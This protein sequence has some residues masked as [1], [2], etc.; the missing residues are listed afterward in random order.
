M[1]APAALA[2]GAGWI[3]WPKS[4]TLYGLIG[5]LGGVA[6]WL[7]LNRPSHLPGRP[8]A[9]EAPAPP[10]T[11]WGIRDLPAFSLLSMVGFLDTGMRYACL[12]LLPFLLLDKG[13]EVEN[14]GFALSLVFVGGAAGKFV[15]GLGAERIGIIRTVVVTELATGLGIAVLPLLPLGA[16]LALLPFLGIAL[17]GTS[18]VLYGCVA[19]F[20]DEHR[21]ARAYSLFYTVGIGSGAIS[22]TV[23]GMIG[24]TLG[25][26]AALTLAG[27]MILPI[28]A[29]CPFLA[30]R[31]TVPPVERAV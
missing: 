21:H 24:D 7:L 19:D 3:G 25:V 31:L 22:P 17:N 14:V 12:P 1:I 27:M 2:L 23:F 8:V 9:P 6:I 15:C 29:I 30:A 4:S 20:V 5:L 11:G 28:L 26:P 10:A 18:S 13:A 16:A